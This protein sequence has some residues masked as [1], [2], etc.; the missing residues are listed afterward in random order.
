MNTFEF[1]TFPKNKLEAL[2][3]AYVQAQDLSGKTPEE[4]LDMYRDAYDKM[5]KHSRVPKSQSK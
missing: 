2:A 1:S 5:L 4:V 3:L